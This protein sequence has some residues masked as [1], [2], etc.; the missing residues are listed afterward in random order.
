MAIALELPPQV[1]QEVHGYA[2]LDGVSVEQMCLDYIKLELQRRREA[3]T[4]MDTFDALATTTSARRSE[5]YV[6]NR[7]D[8]YAETTP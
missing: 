8:A 3:M 2:V 5:P 7:A 6:F 1:A 4:V